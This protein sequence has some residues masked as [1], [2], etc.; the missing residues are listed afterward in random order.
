[1]TFFYTRTPLVVAQGDM[2]LV[3]S[4]GVFGPADDPPFAVFYDLFRVEDGRIVEHWDVIPPSP[5]PDA[6]PHSNG[7]F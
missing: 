6:L 3:G 5:D 2:V 7:F 1:M 4:E